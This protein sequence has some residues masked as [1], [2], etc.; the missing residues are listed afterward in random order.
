MVLMSMPLLVK[1]RL[2]TG[3]SQ[4]PFIYCILALFETGAPSMT[5]LVPSDEVA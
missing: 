3:E 2:V 4:A 1:S 5:K